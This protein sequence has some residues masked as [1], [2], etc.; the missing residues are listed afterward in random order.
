MKVKRV[1]N[2]R[3]KNKAFL[4]VLG[5]H[6]RLIRI[7]NGYSIDRM[8]KEGDQ[9]SP[10]AI[11]RLEMGEADVHVS[12]LY[13]YA[14]VLNIPTKMLMDFEFRSDDTDVVEPYEPNQKR[15]EGCVPFYP[16]EVA[17]GTLDR[18]SE[19]VEPR[20]WVNV[21]RRGGLND[22]FA[23]RVVGR[24]MEPTIPRGSVCLFKKYT[25]GSRNG[26]ILLVQ[27]RGLTDP[28]SGGR[29]VVKRYQRKTS[30]DED[31]DRGHVIIHLVSDNPELQPIILKKSLEEEISTPAIFIEVL[32][33]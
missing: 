29:F 9:L 12:L 22:Y 4:V 15:P 25:G 31:G 10:G 7:K 14:Q 21:G 16:L 27:A 1:A 6:C 8:S 3:Y 5:A 33:S 2:K 32:S 26:K 11:Q 28:E 19:A 20:G 23:A 13:R 30:V 17:A 18:N 24:S